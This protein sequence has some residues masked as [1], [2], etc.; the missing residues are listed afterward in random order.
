MYIYAHSIDIPEKTDTYMHSVVNTCMSP[1]QSQRSASF[2]HSSIQQTR[3]C[4]KDSKGSTENTP[5]R[6]RHRWFMTSTHCKSHLP[7]KKTQVS[8]V[9]P[10][11]HQ[12]KLPYHQSHRSQVHPVQEQTK[13]LYPI[14]PFNSCRPGSLN[15]WFNMLPISPIKGNQKQPWFNHA[16]VFNQDSQN[17]FRWHVFN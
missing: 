16:D 9:N 17:G 13:Q 6:C 3:P 15:R 5:F 14:P 4:Q 2:V 8:V 12:E 10:R 1:K 11:K 7:P